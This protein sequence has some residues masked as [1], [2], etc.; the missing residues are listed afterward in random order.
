MYKGDGPM[1]GLWPIIDRFVSRGFSFCQR[2][3]LAT[4]TYFALRRASTDYMD[5]QNAKVV[6]F[7]GELKQWVEA[8]P[9]SGATVS[10]YQRNWSRRQFDESLMS[11]VKLA[12]YVLVV[13]FL[14]IL[15][16][17]RSVF[18]TVVGFVHTILS[19]AV[20][21]FVY[22]VVL[23]VQWIGFLNA[24]SLFVILGIGADGA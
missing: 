16:Q 4:S 1:M 9:I 12:L 21:G 24:L 6:Q 8:Q 11:D 23:R 3:T 17:V 22:T 7:L 14:L 13:V 5:S 19:L 15:S 2:D 18:L 10:F 20:A